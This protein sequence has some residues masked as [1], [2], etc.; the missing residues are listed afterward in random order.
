LVYKPRSLEIDVFYEKVI[1]Y[2]NQYYQTNLK[3]P[4]SL[5]QGEYGWQEYVQSEPCDNIEQV[6]NY[7][8]QFGM[9]LGFIYAFQG[10]DFHFENII[11]C[12]DK[13]VLVDLETL[14]QSS[15][16]FSEEN[17]ENVNLMASAQVNKTIL[18][19][20]LFN[21]MSFPEDN[22]LTNIGGLIN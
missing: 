1:D 12:R 19:S 14:F 21:Y 20:A 2:V 10:S 15:L 6:R 16:F 9:H 4:L 17:K 13:P 5:D 18:K 11:A 22:G 3:T 8:Y 7:Y